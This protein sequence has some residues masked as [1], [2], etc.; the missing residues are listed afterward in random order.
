[1]RATQVPGLDGRITITQDG[2]GIPRVAAGT[3]ADAWFG[4]G[5]VCAQ[6]RLWQMDYD[7][8]RAAGRL[9]EAA[10]PSAV[11]SDLLARRLRLVDAARADVEAMSAGT[12]AMFEAYAAGVNA[13]LAAAP[14]LPPEYSLTGTR[15]EPW[16]AWHSI[17]VFKVRH[18]LMGMWQAKLALALILHKLGPERFNRLAPGLPI[19]ALK[20]VPPGARIERLQE[21]AVADLESAHH[22]AWLALDQSGSNAWAVHG[23]LTTTGRPVIC[24]DSHRQLDVPN[25]YWQVRVACPEFEVAG[26]TFSGL[27]GFPHFGF[28]GRVA[29]AITHGMADTQDLYVER[30]EVAGTEVRRLGPEGWTVVRPRLELVEVRGRTPIELETWVTANGPVVHGDPREGVALAMRWTASHRPCQQWEVLLPMLRAGSVEELIETQKAWV[31]P[32]NNLVCADSES[33][34]YLCRGEVPVRSGGPRHRLLPV[35]GWTGEHRWTGSVP[36]AS[37]PRA[38]NPEAGFVVTSNQPIIDGDEP[39][40]GWFYADPYR[41]ERVVSRLTERPCHTPEQVIS[42]QADRVSWPAR[43]RFIPMLRTMPPLV[44]PDAEAARAMLAAWDGELLPELP[45]AALYGFF[46]RRFNRQLFQPQVGVELYDWMA[47]AVIPDTAAILRRWW[48]TPY[49]WPP[50][51]DLDPECRARLTAAV[52]ASLG[53]AWRECVRHLGDRPEQWRWDTCH[54]TDARHPLAA[55]HPEAHWLNPPRVGIGGDAD[56]VQ[57]AAYG[58]LESAEFNITGLSVY[59]QVVDFSDPAAASWIVPGGASADPRSPHFADQLPIWARIERIPM[60]PER[61]SPGRV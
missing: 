27:P 17:A 37:M 60:H 12:R 9:A 55:E 8:L 46:R 7:R 15:P 30:F 58:L 42:I 16:E 31:D 53:E 36:T 34:G 52:E 45:A 14:E 25:A 41:A 51:A 59:R 4:M 21:R 54:R 11:P 3:T 43:E 6:D 47:S 23:S 22:L 32:V 13:W 2:Y 40:L 57:A 18:V 44:D 61:L 39:Y 19:G 10:G 1:M 20:H 38:V 29:W 50:P 35:P 56:T 33:I 5:Y 49:L 28:N 24:N 26:A 48:L